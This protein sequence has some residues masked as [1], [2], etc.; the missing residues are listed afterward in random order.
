M[1]LSPDALHR[2]KRKQLAN[3]CRRFGIKAVGK[4]ADLIQRLQQ[5]AAS[6][7]PADSPTK[8]NVAILRH[9][10]R[11]RQSDS[12]Q[13]STGDDQQTINDDDRPTMPYPPLTP[14]TRQKRVSDLVQAIEQVKQE[15]DEMDTDD[16]DDDRDVLDSQRNTIAF[17]T[18]SPAPPRPLL[19]P[20]PAEEEA[21]FTAPLRIIKA[22]PSSTRI[23]S[24][25]S[26]ATILEM[27]T[28][29]V[30][31]SSTSD[32]Y[33][34]LSALPLPQGV[35]SENLAS[36]STLPSITSRQF[37]AAAA[38]VLA[39]MNARLSAAGRSVT[40]GSL[41]TMSSMG[42]GTW[43]NLAASA[44]SQGMSKS[45][46][47]RYE[48]HHEKQFNKMDSIVNHYAARRVGGASADATSKSSQ[49]NDSASSTSAAPAATR[50]TTSTS[51]TRRP[52]VDASTS[53]RGL[54]TIAHSTSTRKLRLPR[55][56]LPIP[57]ISQAKLPPTLST[58]SASTSA[59]IPSRQPSTATT[60]TTTNPPH[61][62]R[63]RLALTED[64][65]T[66][67]NTVLE[68]P[69][70]KKSVMIRVT[71]PERE[72][73]PYKV[74]VAASSL[75]SSSAG[76][77]AGAAGSGPMRVASSLRKTVIKATKGTFVGG[78]SSSSKKVAA[79]SQS[80]KRE[81]AFAKQH[82]QQAVMSRSLSPR[83]NIEAGGGG[84]G[85]GGGIVPSTSNRNKFTG[86][87]TESSSVRKPSA[88]ISTMSGATTQTASTEAS[89]GSG[90][91]SRFGGSIRSSVSQG[92]GRAEAARQARLKE[93][94]TRAKAALA[95]FGSQ[96]IVSA[97]STATTNDSA[98]LTTRKAVPTTPFSPSVMKPTIASLNRSAAVNNTS[99]SLPILSTINPHRP[100]SLALDGLPAVTGALL[101]RAATVHAGVNRT[102]TLHPCLTPRS[103]SLHHLRRVLRKQ[104]KQAHLE[105]ERVTA[106]ENIAPLHVVPSVANHHQHP[107]QQREYEHEHEHE[108][109]E[110][111]EQAGK[112]SIRTVAVRAS[113]N[114]SLGSAET[115]ASVPNRLQ[116]AQGAMVGRPAG[117]RAALVATRATTLALNRL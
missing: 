7:I 2:L 90:V 110:E 62:K 28:R 75:S 40:S 105:Q 88:A 74:S 82:Q 111:E 32:L 6:N 101:Q 92:L 102:P 39:E 19:P 30:P 109:E 46:S 80:H 52:R 11:P 33:P 22:L 57:P 79:S 93:I 67:Q 87:A 103:S 83:A 61:P 16:G 60:S 86:I 51:T 49:T 17:P 5:Y 96:R 99:A 27:A 98:S 54:S 106:A 59:K 3:L 115:F 34:D 58:K 89:K 24:P 81:A 73:L 56:P 36:S 45:R 18:S 50:M 64:Q 8:G 38:S 108:Q 91:S 113:P 70:E 14:C 31:E 15:S 1:L 44:S 21:Q 26:T 25:L 68:I 23:A 37:S 13:E 116:R 53:T 9:V 112:P 84:G 97:A 114:K 48:I 117:P 107:S 20:L 76:A 4:N 29:P 10:K 94:K 69:P 55:R 72:G 65:D 41:A 47:G 43:T 66:L 63:L 100:L 78:G 85:G 71:R 104:Q 42:N 77:G 35:S 12:S 95:G